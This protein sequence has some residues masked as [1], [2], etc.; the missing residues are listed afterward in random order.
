MISLDAN[1]VPGPANH[2]HEILGSRKDED[3]RLSLILISWE[4]FLGLAGDLRQ[5]ERPTE[6]ERTVARTGI[7][8]ERKL[9]TKARAAG[10]CKNR[11][12]H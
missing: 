11:D 6:S 7:I 5:A 4:A 10:T 1:I 12:C 8:R 3:V 2:R 9:R